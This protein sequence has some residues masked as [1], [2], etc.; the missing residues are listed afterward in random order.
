MKRNKITFFFLFLSIWASGASYLA[1]E[2]PKV[3]K[4][5]SYFDQSD[6]KTEN[7]ASVDQQY[8]FLIGFINDYYTV[9][10]NTSLEKKIS[11]LSNQVSPDLK[12]TVINKYSKNLKTFLKKN[13]RRTVDIEKVIFDKESKELRAY[14]KISQSDT[15][16]KSDLVFLVTSKTA[17]QQG[18]ARISLSFYQEI[19]VDKNPSEMNQKTVFISDDAT[20]SIYLPCRSRSVSIDKNTEFVDLK[21]IYNEKLALVKPTQENIGSV[22]LKAACGNQGF[23]ISLLPNSNLLTL[24]HIVKMSEGRAIKTRKQRFFE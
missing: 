2:H 12:K 1:L 20:S 22:D 5:I 13:G 10:G 14:L 6:N 17:A 9:D 23:K 24:R 7:Q 4:I 8:Q 19:P 3:K 21:T 15:D 11:K 18:N 16:S